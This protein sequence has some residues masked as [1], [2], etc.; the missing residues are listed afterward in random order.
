V[1]YLW[2]TLHVL[3]RDVVVHPLSSG[4][5]LR[6]SSCQ[7]L[8]P[9]S[10]GQVW[11]SWRELFRLHRAVLGIPW[12][13]LSQRCY[14]KHPCPLPRGNALAKWQHRGVY[15]MPSWLPLQR[16]S[17]EYYKWSV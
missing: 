3:R 12:P 14:G 9:L 10:C 16:Y 13:L 6:H 4:A 8:H 17:T 1:C 7:W 5:V 2:L 15:S 11:C